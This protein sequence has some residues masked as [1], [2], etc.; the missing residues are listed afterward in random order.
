MESI[1]PSIEEQPS[2]WERAALGSGLAFVAL[3][4][5]AAAVA[6]QA[7]GA[8]ATARQV[9]DW[10]V[11]HREP[12]LAQSYMRGLAATLMPIFV[13]GG[14]SV[15]RR[16]EGQ[17]STLPLLAFGGGVAFSLNMLISNMAGATAAM[18]AGEGVDPG[19]V[20]ALNTL[21]E[22]MRQLNGLSTAVM[23]GAG[24]AVFLRTRSV[25]RWVGR[26]GLVS[27]PIFL[28]GAAGFAGTRL[29]VLNYIAFPL[30]PLWILV[31]SIALLLRSRLGHKVAGTRTT[32][33]RDNAANRGVA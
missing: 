17:I 13:A 23:V 29:E 11:E 26:L 15:I 22:T 19:I 25:P 4:F 12:F 21:G 30:M 31:T 16:K 8:E 7:P 3:L 9:A 20:R 24:S 6:P 5:G 2:R 28:V 27:A 33:K 18:V 32:S 14:L 1:N 10:F